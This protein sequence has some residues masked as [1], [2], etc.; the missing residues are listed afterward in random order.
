MDY[1]IFFTDNLIATSLGQFDIGQRTC[2]SF[3]HCLVDF[4]F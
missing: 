4:D 1:G 2:F 3:D